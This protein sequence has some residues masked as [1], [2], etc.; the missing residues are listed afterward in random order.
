[1]DKYDIN[2]DGYLSREEFRHCAAD[3]VGPDILSD[4]ALYETILEPIRLG[5]DGL[6]SRQIL[7]D[8]VFSTLNPGVELPEEGK[9]DESVAS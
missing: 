2:H 8:Y 7:F 6:M 5:P 3:M 4:D 1:M 9:V